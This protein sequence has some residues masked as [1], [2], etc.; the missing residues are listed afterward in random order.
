[1]DIGRIGAHIVI[2]I[3][4]SFLFQTTEPLNIRVTANEA[5]GSCLCISVD[6]LIRY[7][8][9]CG[10]HLTGAA[11]DLLVA[12]ASFAFCCRGKR[13][14]VM[15]SVARHPQWQLVYYS[16]AKR[17]NDAMTLRNPVLSAQR[18]LTSLDA[19]RRAF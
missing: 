13:S 10:S 5:S 3:L 9:G 7:I 12:S 6:V 11:R 19:V 8:E 2:I 4:L 14:D 18:V 15:L 16:M 1:V 17:Y